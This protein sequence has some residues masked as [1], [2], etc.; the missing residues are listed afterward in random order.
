MYS[1]FKPYDGI[2]TIARRSPVTGKRLT[3]DEVTPDTIKTQLR[4]RPEATTIETPINA[5]ARISS[6]WS[7]WLESRK[8]RFEQE[9]SNA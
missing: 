1:E 7:E 4:A 2:V 6:E 3:E 9:A 8:A 5:K